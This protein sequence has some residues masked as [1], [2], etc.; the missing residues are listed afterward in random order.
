MTEKNIA[1][2][3]ECDTQGGN[4]QLGVRARLRRAD[5]WQL[6]LHAPYW[7]INKTGLPLQLKVI[8]VTAVDAGGPRLLHA[9]I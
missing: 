6:H 4:K 2:S 7:L 1:M 9:F 3:T 5:C 8:G